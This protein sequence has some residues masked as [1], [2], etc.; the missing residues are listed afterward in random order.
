MW[1]DRH[2]AGWAGPTRKRRQAHRFLGNTSEINMIR[3]DPV[4]S[5]FI[6]KIWQIENGRVL[7]KIVFFLASLVMM[8][9]ATAATAATAQPVNM[10][11]TSTY[12]VPSYCKRSTLTGT[13]FLRLLQT[14]IAH[15]DLTDIPFLEKTLGTTLSANDGF[16]AQG[17]PHTQILN[18]HSDHIFDNLI[19]VDLTIYY[20]K[21]EQLRMHEIA[22][23]ELGSRLIISTTRPR[24][25]GRL[26]RQS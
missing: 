19:S 13:E 22:G 5:V 25:P 4:D 26:T 2:V 3:F 15:G 24:P 18:L 11:K 10:P 9:A 17:T 20:S 14:I 23:L 16:S 6:A 7:S 21:S 12:S 8:F 1:C